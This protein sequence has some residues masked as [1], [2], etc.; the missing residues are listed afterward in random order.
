MQCRIEQPSTPLHSL[1]V[2]QFAIA[3]ATSTSSVVVSCQEFIV[4]YDKLEIAETNRSQKRKKP[5][6]EQIMEIFKEICV[7]LCPKPLDK[8][9]CILHL[10]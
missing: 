6:W 1:S 4:A 9:S 7:D 3:M 8:V 2:V 10:Y 5:A